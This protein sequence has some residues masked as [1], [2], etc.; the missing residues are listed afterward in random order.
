MLVKGGRSSE[1]KAK[2]KCKVHVKKTKAKMIESKE[3][4]WKSHIK[5]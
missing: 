1:E 5:G 2:K 4:R 3:R